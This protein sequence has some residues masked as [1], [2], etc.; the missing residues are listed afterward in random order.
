MRKRPPG[1]DITYTKISNWFPSQL[2]NRSAVASDFRGNTLKRQYKKYRAT[3]RQGYS[4]T[5]LTDR[6]SHDVRLPTTR[7]EYLLDMPSGNCLQRRRVHTTR[8]APSKFYTAAQNCLS[9]LNSYL[10]LEG[11]PP[12]EL[13]LIR[14][15]EIRI[16][17]PSGNGE[18]TCPLGEFGRCLPRQSGE[19]T[20]LFIMHSSRFDFRIVVRLGCP[21]ETE[22][23]AVPVRPVLCF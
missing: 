12:S 9:T 15:R 4:Q 22:I 23:H 8:K 6:P 17:G 11:G 20:A 18:K 21:A 16:S 3:G 7:D 2:R 1:A 14:C 10:H 5:T 19:E 13:I